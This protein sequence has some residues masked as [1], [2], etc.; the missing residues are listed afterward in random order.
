MTTAW[1]RDLEEKVLLQDESIK[2]PEA[3]RRTHNLPARVSR[4]VGREQETKT[5]ARLL[6]RS[7]LVTLTGVGGVG[8]TSLALEV[9]ERRLE[10]HPDGAWLVDL[11]A[12]TGP[13]AVAVAVAEALG[14]RTR[15]EE[16]VLSDMVL[17]LANADALLVLDNCEHVVSE[18]AE[19]TAKLLAECPGVKILATSR[20][21]LAVQG[22]ITFGVP[23]L[24]LADDETGG[25][26]FDLFME[27]VEDHSPLVEVSAD[28]KETAHRICRVLDGLPLA[29]ELAAARTRTLSLVELERRLSDR[30]ALLAGGSRTAP[31]RQRT[32]RATLDWSYSLLSDPERQLFGA[33][34]VIPGTFSADVV[35]SV[36]T[37]DSGQDTG[38]DL[39]SALVDKSLV[40][41]TGDRYHLLPTLRRYAAEKI[42]GKLL[43]AIRQALVG[44]FA[45]LAA[46]LET[47]LLTSDAGE[48]EERLGEERSNL[49]S[50]LAWAMMTP[51]KHITSRL[52]RTSKTRSEQT[53]MTRLYR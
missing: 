27:R 16:R 18:A 28:E 13:A 30:F 24:S 8:K 17:R 22:E 44:H 42:D 52:C 37:A 39:F 49:R 2:T 51:R 46:E 48:R 25:D 26:A 47:Q 21:L 10:E 43:P 34:S 12:V 38:L 23:P 50:A 7:R 53:A 40:A 9:A 35:E 45:T 3:P 5:V 14:V 11:A 41:R 20:E 6:G 1:L 15:S 29:I 36:A 32:L 4:F 31:A 33:L 19:L